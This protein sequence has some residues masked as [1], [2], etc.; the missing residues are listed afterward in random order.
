MTSTSTIAEASGTLSIPT[1][2]GITHCQVQREHGPTW[3]VCEW[4]VA[5]MKGFQRRL[6]VTDGLDMQAW[7]LERFG[8]GKYRL[9]LF[10][11]ARAA[12]FGPPFELMDP[13][14]PQQPHRIGTPAA[15]LPAA[16]APGAPYPPGPPISNGF[17]GGAVPSWLQLQEL[18]ERAASREREAS[19]ERLQAL[20]ADEDE[21]RERREREE[22]A[23][24]RRDQEESDRREAARERAA[25]AEITAMR[26]R[27]KLDLER[28]K[29]DHEFRL[30]QMAAE[31]PRD[32]FA[33]ALAT[34][35]E[36]LTERFSAEKTEKPSELA[37]FFA[38]VQ[39]HLPAVVGTL[40]HVG[41]AYAQNVA[42]RQVPP[43]HM[44]PDGHQG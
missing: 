32:D 37:K 16:P 44:P 40:Q 12:G 23:R 29:L 21:R 36:R 20:R 4:Y 19:L 14:R 1:G 31:S 38:A 33:D 34:L 7:I 3:V 18:Q 6:D 9:G 15:P 41:R 11:G 25:A 43:P 22:D 8:S 24:R 42:A 39:P 26:E 30:Q 13:E 35:E 5:E 27:H 28:M 17:G 2:R 10:R